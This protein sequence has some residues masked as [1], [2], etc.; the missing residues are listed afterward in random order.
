MPEYHC[1]NCGH[2]GQVEAVAPPQPPVGT[3]VKD[4]FGG[5]SFH[6]VQDGW[7]A[8]GLMPF[9]KWEAMWHARGPLI[10]CG[11]WGRPLEEEEESAMQ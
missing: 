7:G 6:A 11:P 8:P 2:V 9:G 4:R 10:V 1:S 3:W 5:T